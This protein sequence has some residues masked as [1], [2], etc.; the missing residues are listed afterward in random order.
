[1]RRRAWSSL[2]VLGG[3]GLLKEFRDNVRSFYSGAEVFIDGVRLG[4]AE[5]VNWT[6]RGPQEEPGPYEA[7][8]TMVLK[9][10][11]LGVSRPA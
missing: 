9:P 4:E 1:M 6:R 11:C 3:A 7:T 10:R 5:D 8:A 2:P